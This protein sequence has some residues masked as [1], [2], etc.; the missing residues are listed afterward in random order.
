MTL[1]ELL[2]GLEEA[3]EAKKT[4]SAEVA[5]PVEVAKEAEIPAHFLQKKEEEKKEEKSEA[6]PEEKKEEEKKEEDKSEEKKAEN[7]GYVYG[8]I[9]ARGFIE[10]LHKLAENPIDGHPSSVPTNKEEMDSKT[11]G[12]VA[13]KAIAKKDAIWTDEVLGAPN[14][15]VNQPNRDSLEPEI[16]S[17]VAA[18]LAALMVANHAQTHSNVDEVKIET[19]SPKVG[20]KGVQMRHDLPYS[21]SEGNMV[22]DIVKNKLIGKITQR[23]QS[24]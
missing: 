15:A 19:N 20:D 13:S 1:E 6:K 2:R 24:K 10:T 21:D 5:K 9:M 17:K 7:E 22:E 4:A 16:R 11:Q 14:A 18:K 23:M 12:A 8:Q 3:T